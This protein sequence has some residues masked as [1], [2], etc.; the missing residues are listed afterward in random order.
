MHVLTSALLN[1][2]CCNTYDMFVHRAEC[3]LV[4]AQAVSS[5]GMC[6]RMTELTQPMSG[7][8]RM[9]EVACRWPTVTT[10]SRWLVHL[11]VHGYTAESKQPSLA[12][13]ANMGRGVPASSH[14]MHHAIMVGMNITFWTQSVLSRLPTN[15]DGHSMGQTCPATHNLVARCLCEVEASN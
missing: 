6:S 11:M 10:T 15:G 12:T 9:H 1:V 4:M 2:S 3:A 8:V 7:A 14:M 13:M 5:L